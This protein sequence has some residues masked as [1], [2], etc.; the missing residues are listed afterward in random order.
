[1]LNNEHREEMGCRHMEERKVCVIGDSEISADKLECV[2]RELEREIGAALDE[3]CKT[4][5]VEYREGAGMLF[6][7]CV[8]GRRGEYPDIFLEAVLPPNP[9]QLDRDLLAGC[10]AVKP[11]CED[12]QQDYPLSVTRY[13]VGQAERVLVVCGEQP[14]RDTTYALD[15][16][17]TMGR[18]LRIIEI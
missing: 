18:D 1:M 9:D 6:A 7:R 14:D 12:C 4:F 13:L 17:R 16:A 5:V 10:S 8:A 3:G 15:Y 2:Q 11:L